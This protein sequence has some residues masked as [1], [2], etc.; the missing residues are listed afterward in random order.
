MPEKN[1]I[2]RLTGAFVFGFVLLVLSAVLVLVLWPFL[3]P[4][5]GMIFPFLI[6]A[7]LYIV[8][9]LIVWGLLLMFTYLGVAVYYAVKHPMKI[10]KHGSYSIRKTKEAGK[11]QKGRK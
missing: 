3:M 10:S 11:R 7:V 9:V 2:L 1:Y 6:G 4:F 8:V 5:F